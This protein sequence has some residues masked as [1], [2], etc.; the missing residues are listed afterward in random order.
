MK[1]VD[2]KHSELIKKRKCAIQIKDDHI[3]E[4][5]L[6]LRDLRVQKQAKQEKS[7]LVTDMIEERSEQDLDDTVDQIKPK[8]LKTTEVKQ[9]AS[10]KKSLDGT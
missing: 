2:K 1:D 9:S 4:L 7:L 6:D 8:D 5:K 3:E 10:L